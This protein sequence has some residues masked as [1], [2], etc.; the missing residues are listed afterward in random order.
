MI[1]KYGVTT[2]KC[3]QLLIICFCYSQVVIN[4]TSISDYS[5]GKF[6]LKC[7]HSITQTAKPNLARHTESCSA[8]TLF[9]TQCPNFFTKSQIELKYHIVKK[10]SA[11]KPVV[12][13]KS[14]FCNQ[15]FPGFCAL[16]RH[17]NTQHA[18]P[19]KTAN[20]DLDDIIN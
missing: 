17:K 20:V 10:H 7:F 11:P 14:K 13:F 1:R 8:G 16:R 4:I 5:V 19:M 2:A 3:F 9:C 15:E 6:L 18:F 12:N